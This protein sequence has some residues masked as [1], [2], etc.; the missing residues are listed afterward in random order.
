MKKIKY[1]CIHHSNVQTKTS[2]LKAI[3][4]YHKE[5]F[6]MKSKLGYWVGYH[7]HIS[8]D[9]TKTQTR[10]MDEESAAVIGHN[11]DSIH[12][13]LDGDFNYNLPTKKQEEALTELLES[14][15]RF[16][17][18]AKVVL[19]REIQK[20]RTCPGHLFTRFFLETQILN[21]HTK[22][23]DKEDEAKKE[24]IQAE[25]LKAQKTLL[26]LLKELWKRLN[27]G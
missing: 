3:D 26:I 13:E 22:P 2:Q 6:G 9:G 7:M 21:L 1:I 8:P 12:I 27:K 23:D 18:D 14:M 15:L 24:A 17:P 5:K 11:S 4:N 25:L 20:N 16:Y 10:M 19:H